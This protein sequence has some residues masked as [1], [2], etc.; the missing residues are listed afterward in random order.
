M[1]FDRL[2]QFIC[3]SFFIIFLN[4]F[5]FNFFLLYWIC[6][7]FSFI[8]FLLLFFLA[9]PNLIN[10]LP[11][12]VCSLKFS[13]VTFFLQFWSFILSWVGAKLR[14]FFFSFM[15]IFFFRFLWKLFFLFDLVYIYSYSFID[16]NIFCTSLE[17]TCVA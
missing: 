1:R 13:W 6:W 12:F 8:I 5:L 2:T 7:E 10:Q 9:Y 17:N 15:V 16:T 14:Q 11:Y 3:V 4:W